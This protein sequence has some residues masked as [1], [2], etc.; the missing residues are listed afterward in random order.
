MGQKGEAK[1]QT[2]RSDTILPLLG[3]VVNSGVK[4]YL[5]S[6]KLIPVDLRLGVLDE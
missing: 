6:T 2:G 1:R 5:Y 3:Q 4:P